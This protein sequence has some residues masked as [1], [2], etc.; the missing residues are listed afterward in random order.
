MTSTM[1][2]HL[3]PQDV[4][5]SSQPGEL[6]VLL[7]GGAPVH[8]GTAAIGGQVRDI[9]M[10]FGLQPSIAAVDFLSIALAVTAADTF[11]LRDNSDNGWSR[12]ISIAL[13]LRSPGIWSNLSGHLERALSFLSGDTWN[14][15]FLE[16][17][18]P[19]PTRSA[20]SARRK[21][22]DVSKI[23]VVSLF[24]GG[25]DST[26]STLGLIGD[27][28]KPLLVSHAYRGDAQVQQSIASILPI[29]VEHL[30]VN[31]HP[32]WDGNTDITMRTRSFNFIALAVLAAQVHSSFRG[33]RVA[34]VLV[35]ENGL[36]ALNAPL[37]PR[38]IGA[39][40][41]RTTHPHFLR[42]MGS[43]LEQAGFS[44]KINNPYEMWTKGE[45]VASKANYPNF[46]RIAA[47]T[48]SCGKWKRTNQQCGCCVPCLIRRA[49]LYAGGV[50]DATDYRFM[51]LADVMSDEDDRDDLIAMATATRRLKVENVDR[52]VARSGP[53][54]E[55]RRS[56]LVDVHKR[57][58]IEVSQFLKDSGLSI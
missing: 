20:I 35:P 13:P 10:R 24:S 7:Y 36:I 15:Q 44:I 22:V 31:F 57:G 30:S 47:D 3:R 6:H 55:D 45:M 42:L 29:P 43:V 40:S 49:S 21:W 23:D 41:T 51:N 27:G 38:R 12:N 56:A 32:T 19:P 26:I 9:L 34:E 8:S 2:F 37:T 25:L 53:L 14:F 18:E 4:P 33:G 50:H 5:S 58:L 54:P 52:W 48:V 17:G 39:L 16:G 1:I 46:E 11:I 28:K